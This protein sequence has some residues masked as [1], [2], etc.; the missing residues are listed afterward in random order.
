MKALQ[1]IEHVKLAEVT[2]WPRV[3]GPGLVNRVQLFA[4]HRARTFHLTRYFISGILVLDTIYEEVPWI[5]GRI[6]KTI[7]TTRLQPRANIIPRQTKQ[8]GTQRKPRLR[9]EC[10]GST[11]DSLGLRLN[12]P[13]QFVTLASRMS[14]HGKEAN[15]NRRPKGRGT[16]LTDRAINTKYYLTIGARS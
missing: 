16:E 8:V 1:R 3:A 12:G 6:R 10:A 9:G 11:F 2:P 4:P 7:S 5:A 15:L 13:V 14:E